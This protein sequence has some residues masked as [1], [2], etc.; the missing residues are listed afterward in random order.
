MNTVS[1]VPKRSEKESLVSKYSIPID[2][3]DFA[4][5]KSCKNGRELEQI[6]QILR[7]GEEGYFPD[8][9]KCVEEQ[10]YVV[11]PNSIF[12][13]SA[14]PVLS[15]Q[16]IAK[17]EW[18]KLF[19]DMQNWIEDIKRNDEELTS[20]REI[21]TASNEIPIRQLKPLENQ[22]SK[23]TETA[24]IKSMD[25]QA[26]DKLDVDAEILKLDLEEERL[27]KE[28]ANEVKRRER[29][30]RVVIDPDVMTD[31]ELSHAAVKARHSGNDHFRL[32]DYEEALMYYSD[33]LTLM[34]TAATY[35]NRAMTNIKLEKYNDALCDCDEVLKLE[36]CNEKAL[37]RKSV[38][39]KN[40]KKYK[41]ALQYLERLIQINPCNTNAQKLI[42]ALNTLPDIAKPIRTVRIKIEEEKQEE[43]RIDVTLSIAST[44]KYPGPYLKVV[45]VPEKVAK[46]IANTTKSLCNSDEKIIDLGIYAELPKR[47]DK[48]IKYKPI[49][50]R[51]KQE[52]KKQSVENSQIEATENTNNIAQEKIEE[53]TGSSDEPQYAF[54]VNEF[55]PYMFITH[56]HTLK[57]DQSYIGHERLL[58]LLKPDV[59]VKGCK[60]DSETFSAILKC[61]DK[62]FCNASDAKYLNNV[63]TQ[64]INMPRFKIILLFM[65]NQE[66]DIVHN[67][68]AF[69]KHN[70]YELSQDIYNKYAELISMK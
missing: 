25:Y 38:A 7:S 47:K 41:K 19:I 52:G 60:L 23:M 37:Y 2:H 11:K 62:R 44:S 45:S 4:Y 50:I 43:K 13:Q 8:L 31:A 1:E 30:N 29:L 17:A 63:L 39:L 68:I 34:P 67:L 35:N 55:K 57:H 6:L 66:K 26:W 32:E 15:K 65:N 3:L 61:L 5:V 27:K 24:R 49:Q 12:L 48:S 20:F 22:N 18:N 46:Q 42:K 64:F 51:D 69:V 40:L 56:L 21:K 9:L 16:D 33:S 10:L 70:G 28:N 14:V 59:L 36:P 53:T 58:R 54:D